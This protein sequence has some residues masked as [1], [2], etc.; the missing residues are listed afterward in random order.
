MLQNN[1]WKKD[2]KKFDA[3]EIVYNSIGNQK[4]TENISDRFVRKKQKK[5]KKEAL[6]IK[7]KSRLTIF[8]KNTVFFKKRGKMEAWQRTFLVF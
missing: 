1:T 5:T 8:S 7:D 2:W 4:F 6:R 3:Y